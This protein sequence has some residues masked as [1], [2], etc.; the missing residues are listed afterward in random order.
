ML[1]VERI[2][3]ARTNRLRIAARSLAAATEAERRLAWFAP[4]TARERLLMHGPRTVHHLMDEMSVSGNP[5]RRMLETDLVGWLP[6]NLL[7]RGD[8]M[9][10]AASVELRPP[11]LDHDLVDT[12]FRLPSDVKVRKGTTKWVVKR[13]AAEFLPAG[14]VHRRKA[15]FR[16]PL[17]L[18]FREGLR[19][20]AHD[21]L[22]ARDSFVTQV[23]SRQAVSALLATHAAQ[24]RN[25]DIRIW[26][27]LSLEV[28]HD[29]FFGSGT[30]GISASCGPHQRAIA[31]GL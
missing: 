19:G 12:A 30:A 9:T 6:D 10:M 5:L 3:P 23:L 1:G 16:V 26:T 28:W 2:L 13:V 11:F 21:R 14:I 7:E 24:R 18:W 29:T 8:R 22:L 31:D 25:E 27:L 20:M 17:D 15:G 4:F